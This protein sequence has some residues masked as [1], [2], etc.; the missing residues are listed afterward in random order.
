MLVFS[1]V[2]FGNGSQGSLT[3]NNPQIVNS[4][5]KITGVAGSNVTLLNTSSFPVAV[6]DVVLAINMA[7]GHYE[8]RNV[9]NVAGNTVDIGTGNVANANFTSNSQ[10]VLVP[11]YSN[12]T[13]VAGGKIYCPLWNGDHEP[14]IP[15]KDTIGSGKRFSP[16][17]IGAIG[18][19][20][21]VGSVDALYVILTSPL[22]P[23]PPTLD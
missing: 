20:N 8:L 6:G 19:N 18:L 11:Q 5:K 9:I 15:F 16:A 22:A 21:G 1:Q 7:S 3:V 23:S 17:Q 10:L 12:L 13:V 14:D 4:Y 2:N